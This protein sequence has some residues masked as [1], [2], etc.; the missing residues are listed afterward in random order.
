MQLNNFPVILDH[1][2]VAETVTLEGTFRFISSSINTSVIK[3]NEETLRLLKLCDGTRTVSQIIDVYSQ[4]Y[5]R[6][7]TTRKSV[8]DTL[9]QLEKL[10]VICF[11]EKKMKVK[12][13]ISLA[14]LSYPL[15]EV[16]LEI[17]NRCNLNC[18]HCY[19]D[20]GSNDGELSTKEWMKVIDELA[21]INVAEVILSGG[22]PLLRED[23]F[24][25]IKFI[26]SKAIQVV[27]STNGTLINESVADKIKKLSVKSVRVSL[28]APN[29]QMHDA[30]RG[31]KGTFE[32]V[33]K[34]VKILREKDIHVRINSCIT[35]DNVSL[36]PEM[37]QLIRELKVNEYKFFI[38][39]F[40]GR[41]NRA[42]R[43]FSPNDYDEIQFIYKNLGLSASLPEEDLRRNMKAEG[44]INCYVGR[45]HLVIG[46]NGEVIPCLVFDRKLFVLGNVRL[47]SIK[48]I[49]EK[50]EMLN[51]LRN[52]DVSKVPKCGKCSYL[53]ACRGGCRARA[54]NFSS[55]LY[56]P[57]PFACILYSKNKGNCAIN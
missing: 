16:F 47:K 41:K 37:L 54:F 26:R 52:I 39:Y 25:L 20:F 5:G 10:H 55:D 32:K 30:F 1:V 29:P 27:L 18:P 38:V 56:K 21:S 43:L 53:L 2:K 45:N 8:I 57:D 36:L 23:I 35:K 46:P 49:W 48:D 4:E 31:V 6:T 22:E 12:N 50:S 40:T 34:A 33:I 11:V 9:S 14:H 51:M 3:I 17:T 15:N 13:K 19:G 24:S 42:M 44:P 7:Q 28:D